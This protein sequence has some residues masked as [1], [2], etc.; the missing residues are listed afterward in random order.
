MYHTGGSKR[1]WGGGRGPFRTEVS[2]GK[3][4]LDHVGEAL[5]VQGL[6]DVRPPEA[7]EVEL[8]HAEPLRRRQV[9]LV[10]RDALAEEVGGGAGVDRGGHS[11]PVRQVRQGEGWAFRI[12]GTHG[13]QNQQCAEGKVHGVAVHNVRS[14]VALD[15]RA[16]AAAA[17]ERVV[18]NVVDDQ[19]AGVQELGEGRVPVEERHIHV[20]KHVENHPGCMT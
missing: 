6:P 10:A 19:R 3:A 4:R 2:R 5:D 17:E 11:V 1:G 9:G 16:R 13:A 8:V 14:R 18:L 15:V 7:G 12:W 20:M